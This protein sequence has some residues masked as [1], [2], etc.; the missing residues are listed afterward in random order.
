MTQ[1]KRKPTILFP[2]REVQTAKK[3]NIIMHYNNTTNIII[4]KALINNREKINS[5][6]AFIFSLGFNNSRI[7]VLF[8]RSRMS[9]FDFG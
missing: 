5:F 9:G 1:M 8:R 2:E 6:L 4:R 7:L 3:Y